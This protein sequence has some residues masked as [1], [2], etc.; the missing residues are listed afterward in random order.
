MSESTVTLATADGPMA[1]DEATPDGE[2]RGAV[3]VIQE[4]FGVNDHIRDVTRRFATAGYLAV[5]PALFHRAGGGT[6]DY[7]DF[8]AVIPLFEGVTDASILMDV[9][10]TLAHLHDR[11]FDDR[12][13]AIVGFCFGGRVSFLVSAR[14]TLGAG[15]GFYGSG[16]VQQ[17]ALPF[18]P[19]VGEA[20]TLPTPW[21]GLFGDEDG[22]IPVEDVETL[23]DA[24]PR[25][26]GAGRGRPVCGRRARL[27][28]R[29]PRVVPPRGRRRRLGAHAHVARRPPRLSRLGGRREGQSEGCH[30]AW[31]LMNGAWHDAPGAPPNREQ[32]ML[33]GTARADGLRGTAERHGRAARSDLERATEAAWWAR[34]WYGWADWH[35]TP[36]I[37]VLAAVVLGLDVLT[38]WVDVGLGH[39]GRIPVS[40]ALPFALLL[41]LRIGLPGLGV[42]RDAWHRWREFGVASLVTLTIC[43]ALYVIGVAG[44]GEA[45]GL[46]VA[47]L[48]EELVYRLA[49]LIVI[50]ALVAGAAGR[51]WRHP[52]RW[53]T[54]PGVAALLTAAFAF[55]VLPGHV[56]QMANVMT[57]VPFASLALVLG[58]VVLRTG[59]LWPTVVAHGVLNLVTIGV[60]VTG[61]SAVLRLVVAGATLLGLVAAADLA[62][63]RSGRLRPVPSVIDLTVVSR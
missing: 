61:G 12:H 49:A 11:G 35:L 1:C 26:A 59:A 33:G 6:A 46:V 24:L 2:P 36:G 62:G 18:D 17:G 39:L 57:V 9:D 38:A 54:G 52:A 53:G 60:L 31:S 55:S 58:W 32:A 23:R 45:L 37:V 3:I 5:A 15:V 4:A 34:R 14:R 27:P 44:I 63:R 50:G 47:A 22:G 56:A 8:G 30:G 48:G 43:V 28:L 42:S 20:A 16:I 25:R 29:P 40:P 7:G 51:D 13:I 21:L 19:L 41:A 10:A